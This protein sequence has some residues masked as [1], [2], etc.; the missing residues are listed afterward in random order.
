MLS[1]KQ[2][3]ALFGATIESRPRYV[4]VPLQMVNSVRELNTDVNFAR[5]VAQFEQTDDR[6]RS[7][8]EETLHTL[9]HNSDKP[10]TA[11]GVRPMN[12]SCITVL[13][14][15]ASVA[16][17]ASTTTAIAL[18]AESSRSCVQSAADPPLAAGW[19]RSPQ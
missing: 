10:M 8:T 4:R 2:K 3:K 5:L 12:R 6:L 19:H 16:G 1:P 9:S 13:M 15:R 11:C 7:S 14:C 17:P 18:Q